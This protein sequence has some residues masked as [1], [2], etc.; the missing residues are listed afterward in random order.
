M[1]S[2]EVKLTIKVGDDGTLDVVAKKAKKAAKATEEVGK[3][4]DK[5]SRSR[6][7]YS[8]GEKG[9]AGATNNST[10]AFSKMRDSMTGGGGLVPA[11]ATLSA[12]VFALSAAF[13]VLRRAAQVE[14]I[15]RAHV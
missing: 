11:Y 1:A 10:K 2:N 6:K 7:N 3:S 9:V 8:K 12:N 13:N 5:A 4:T 15:G 14:Q